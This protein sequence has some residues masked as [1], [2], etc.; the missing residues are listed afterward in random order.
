MQIFIKTNYNVFVLN[1][2]NT[3]KIS[4]IREMITDRTSYPDNVYYLIEGCKVL[5]NGD[6]NLAEYNIKNQA[7]IEVFIHSTNKK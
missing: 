5:S 1:V 2:D 7:T 4:K 6:Y 3:V